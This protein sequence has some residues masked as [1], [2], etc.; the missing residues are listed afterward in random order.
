MHSYVHYSSIYNSQDMK[1]TQMPINRRTDKE[2][3]GY[4]S[5]IKRMKFCIYNDMTDLENIMLS[6]ISQAEKD[7]YNVILLTCGI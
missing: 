5:A 6:E 2:G 1:A 3:V 4:Y 7:K